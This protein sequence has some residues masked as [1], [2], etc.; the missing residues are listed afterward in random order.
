MDGTTSKFVSIERD[1][2]KPIS[3]ESVVQ[4]KSAKG[5]AIDIT[6]EDEPQKV[7]LPS[8]KVAIEGGDTTYHVTPAVHI[9]TK[10]SSTM[11]DSKGKTHVVEEGFEMNLIHPLSGGDGAAVAL[12][13]SVAP[14][15]IKVAA[16]SQLANAPGDPLAGLDGKPLETTAPAKAAPP[17]MGHH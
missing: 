5:P 1:T 16:P 10:S 12:A 3:E 4:L 15:A 11:V 7:T 9:E 2:T 6:V 14:D 13:R 8:G 17:K